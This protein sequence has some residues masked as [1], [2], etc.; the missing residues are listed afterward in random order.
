MNIVKTTMAMLAAML[1]QGCTTL[2]TMPAESAFKPNPQ[3]SEMLVTWVVSDDPTSEC[4]RLAPKLQ[5]HPLIPACAKWSRTAG[6]CTVVTATTT[7]HQIL[8]HEVRHCFEGH[9]HAPLARTDH[10]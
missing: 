7:S 5:M 3:A 10:D 1:L 2:V 4:K 6:T 8:G 9:F